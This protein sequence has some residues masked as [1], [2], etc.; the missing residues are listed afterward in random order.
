VPPPQLALQAPQESQEETTQSKGARTTVA[1]CTGKPLI[2]PNEVNTAVKLPVEV[3]GEVKVTVSWVDV[4]AVTVPAAPL[5]NVTVLLAAVVSNPV[6]AMIIVA[7]L[8]GRLVLLVIT[9][10]AATAVATWTAL[11]LLCPFVVTVAVRLPV[12]DGSVVKVTVSWFEVAA[13][14]VPTAPR[15]NATILL[16]AVGSN[17]VPLMVIVVALIDRDAE[18][19]LTFGRGAGVTELLATEGLPVPIV[20]VAVTL[21]V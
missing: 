17:P 10:G 14:T 20:L 19:R 1:T 12:E 7:A 18:F 2:P 5:L 16:A 6:P 9:V 11:P 8:R 15:L 21:K 4:V 13:V 3:G